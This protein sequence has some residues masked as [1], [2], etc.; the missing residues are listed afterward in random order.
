MNLLSFKVT[1]QMCDMI[2]DDPWNHAAIFYSERDKDL[3]VNYISSMGYE[4]KLGNKAITYKDGTVKHIWR[5]KY[6]KKGT[7]EPEN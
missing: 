2:L 4:H 6:W 1:K 3:F 5:V 7:Y